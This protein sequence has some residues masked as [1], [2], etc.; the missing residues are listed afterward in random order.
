MSKTNEFDFL[1]SWMKTTLV[2]CH[3][4]FQLANDQAEVEI[5]VG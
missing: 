4:L 3:S 2:A 1:E 5:S